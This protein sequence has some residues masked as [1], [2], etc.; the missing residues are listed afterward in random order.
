MANSPS[1]KEISQALA[2]IKHPEID[3]TLVDLGMLQDISMKSK[4]ITVTLKLPVMGIPIQVKD[5]LVNSVNQALANLD[6]SLE[7]AITL[8]QM[9]PEER[10]QFF[11]MAR[12][13]W[14]E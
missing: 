12:A 7:G 10:S 5:Y 1:E 13:N 2:E 9:S 4:K 6:V 14:I 11:T 3:C 8:A